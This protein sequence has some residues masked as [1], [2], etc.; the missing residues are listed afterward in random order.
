MQD[1]K[2]D[3]FERSMSFLY[4]MVP[5]K[6][7]QRIARYGMIVGSISLTWYRVLTGREIT[8]N[9]FGEFDEAVS[10]EQRELVKKCVTEVV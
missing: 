5:V 1:R 3:I 2:G 7:L 8:D 6:Q 9:P 4:S 10:A